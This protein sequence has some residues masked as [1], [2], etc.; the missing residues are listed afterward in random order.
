MMIETTNNFIEAE[1][2]EISKLLDSETNE[3]EFAVY[4]NNKILFIT[5]KYGIREIWNQLDYLLRE[6]E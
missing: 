4:A 6:V 2:F 3:S 1:S 5:D